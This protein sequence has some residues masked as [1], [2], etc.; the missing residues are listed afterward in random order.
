MGRWLGVEVRVHAFFPLL[1]VVCMGLSASDLGAFSLFR[2]LGLFLVLVAAVL[3]RET[4]RLL[5]AAWLNLRLR[6]IL[7]L[8]IGGLYAYANPESQESANQGSGQFAMALAGPLA[9]GVT[10]LMLAANFLG[11]SGDMR[12]LDQPFIT[13]AYLLRS[14]VWM[15]AWAWC[16]CCRPTPWTAGGSSGAD[17]P[18]NS[19]SLLRAAPRPA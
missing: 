14:M 16:I 2:G 12:L 19:A 6:A 9:N 4:A 5:V 18:T 8:P 15:Q 3:V 1:A 7:L 17:S 11:T 10:A 13:S